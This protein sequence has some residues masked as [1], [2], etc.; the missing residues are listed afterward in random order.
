MVVSEDFVKLLDLVAS[1]FEELQVEEG[2]AAQREHLQLGVDHGRLRAGLV[3]VP[4]LGRDVPDQVQ[5]VFVHGEGRLLRHPVVL[6]GVARQNEEQHRFQILH[7]LQCSLPLK[8]QQFNYI[9]FN[10]IQFNSV[11]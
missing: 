11:Q 9:Q 10:S 7:G 3:L 1:H 2:L 4:E 8:Q 5:C 6:H